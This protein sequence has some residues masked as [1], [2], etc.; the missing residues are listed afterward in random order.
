MAQ[1]LVQ[2]GRRHKQVI[3]ENNAGAGQPSRWVAEGGILY[4]QKS[5]SRL[6]ADNYMGPL[7]MT[8]YESRHV[9]HILEEMSLQNRPEIFG[10]L[11]IFSS[12]IRE[13]SEVLV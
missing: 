4:H 5:Y 9:A 11:D 10:K 8:Q 12:E 13:S 2:A 7:S 3:L 1:V 6:L